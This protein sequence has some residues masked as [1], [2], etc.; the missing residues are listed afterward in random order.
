MTEIAVSRYFVLR[1]HNDYLSL[2][3][4]HWGKGYTAVYRRHAPRLIPLVQMK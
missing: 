1:Y 4:R 2:S 3:K